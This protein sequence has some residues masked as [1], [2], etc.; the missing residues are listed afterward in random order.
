MNPIGRP[1]NHPCERSRNRGCAFSINV[2]ACLVD[3]LVIYAVLILGWR[4]CAGRLLTHARSSRTFLPLT[5][6]WIYYLVQG[7][8]TLVCIGGAVYVVWLGLG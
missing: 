8:L 1:S 2:V 6:R 7:M 5:G 4:G 3:L